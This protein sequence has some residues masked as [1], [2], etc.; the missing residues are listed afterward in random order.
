[1]EWHC[2]S[3]EHNGRLARSR[4]RQSQFA[5][6]PEPADDTVPRE[7]VNLSNA[8]SPLTSNPSEFELPSPSP[9]FP[10]SAANFSLSILDPRSFLDVS[11]SEVQRALCEADCN[12]M[13]GQRRST[14]PLRVRLPRLPSPFSASA[15]LIWLVM[16]GIRS[17]QDG[18]TASI[19]WIAETQ[20]AA[21]VH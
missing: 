16:T 6:W 4:W 14:P 17:W 1:V 21:P 13:Q 15:G 10:R 11:P 5:D 8:L 2:N 12:A 19:D 9:C 18:I 20:A 3:F 7:K